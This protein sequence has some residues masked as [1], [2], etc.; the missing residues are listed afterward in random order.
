MLPGLFRVPIGARPAVRSEPM[1]GW[2]VGRLVWMAGWLVL[3]RVRVTKSAVDGPVE[4]GVVQRDGRT[5]AVRSLVGV[6]VRTGVCRVFRVAIRDRRTGV[7]VAARAGLIRRTGV[8]VVMRAGLRRVRAGRTFRS[9]VR[10]RRL[11]PLMCSWKR[12]TGPGRWFPT[13]RSLRPG[14]GRFRRLGRRFRVSGTPVWGNR[15]R[16]DRPVAIPRRNRLGRRP[17]G[18]CSPETGRRAGHL[19]RVGCLWQREGRAWSLGR[20]LR[21][22]LRRRDRVRP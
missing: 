1:G 4:T 19:H 7:T 8:A 22:T 9:S 13:R 5:R 10:G 21:R 20:P 17:L 6:P 16:R 18:P 2:P 11:G 3:A 15:P 12:G 14:L